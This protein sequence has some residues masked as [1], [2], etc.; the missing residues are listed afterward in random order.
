MGMASWYNPVDR[1]KTL[2]RNTFIFPFG[3]QTTETV[4]PRLEFH[5]TRRSRKL[6]AWCHLMCMWLGQGRE[7]AEFPGKRFHG[8]DTLQERLELF[9]FCLNLDLI[10]EP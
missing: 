3:S 10:S 6:E 2:R 7:G 1:I 5:H 8:S 9:A 4:G